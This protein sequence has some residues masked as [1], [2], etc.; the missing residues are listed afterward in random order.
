MFFLSP[1]HIRCTFCQQ[2]LSLFLIETTHFLSE[3]HEVI[4]RNR[5]AKV[6]TPRGDVRVHVC[7][8]MSV[9]VHVSVWFSG[10]PLTFASKPPA[11]GDI[12]R[13]RCRVNR[14]KKKSSGLK[15]HP[16]RTELAFIN[17]QRGEKRWWRFI[18]IKM[19]NVAIS[20]SPCQLTLKLILFISAPSPDSLLRAIRAKFDE[21]DQ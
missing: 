5:S 16:T 14:E 7:V 11:V 12:W 1:Q 3:A 6:A 8:C 15:Y 17:I 18:Q 13:R 10:K 2:Y 4:F 20:Q 9:C 19:A 21:N